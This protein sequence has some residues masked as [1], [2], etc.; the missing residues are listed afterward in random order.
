M[1]SDL[2]KL[3][4]AKIR[5]DV[6]KGEKMIPLLGALM[7]GD[8]EHA[9]ELCQNYNLHSNEMT[10]LVDRHLEN[11]LKHGRDKKFDG[12]KSIYPGGNTH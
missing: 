10:Q 11:L 5:A 3:K 1:K 12:M 2:D 7:S 4:H 8:M 6:Q 9:M